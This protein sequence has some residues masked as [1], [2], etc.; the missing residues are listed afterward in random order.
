MAL[1][2]GAYIWRSAHI[3]S[4]S[5]NAGNTETQYTN[6]NRKT[7]TERR[8]DVLTLFQGRRD[9]A[10]VHRMS[11]KK[12]QASAQAKSRGC[13]LLRCKIAFSLP[14]LHLHQSALA[15]KHSACRHLDMMRLNVAG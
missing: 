5:P 12:G 11:T 9:E 6:K 10:D 4:R 15:F 13:C 1:S 14:W 7:E 8:D 3:D 2:T